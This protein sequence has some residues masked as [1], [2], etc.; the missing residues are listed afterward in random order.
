MREIAGAAGVAV[1]TVY[2]T[3]GSKAAILIRLVDV[4]VVGDDEPVPLR[5]RPEYSRLGKGTRATRA[6]AVAELMWDINT[7]IGGLERA[8]QQ[9]AGVDESFAAMQAESRARQL[10]GV[11][12]AIEQMG[13]SS[14]TE[15]QV[16]GL[17]AVTCSDV[18]MLLTREVGVGRETYVDWL[19]A[20]IEEHLARG[21]RRGS[22][23]SPT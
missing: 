9:G 2:A 6:R 22:G 17:L 13:V 11:R 19:A 4:A 8:V 15:E 10:C 1:E 16:V 23:R 21:A 5:D 20:T 7:R 3:V 18:Y 14:P 12:E